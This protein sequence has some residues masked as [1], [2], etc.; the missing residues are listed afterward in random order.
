MNNAVFNLILL[1]TGLFLLHITGC[2]KDDVPFDNTALYAACGTGQ[3]YARYYPDGPCTR[4][5][6]EAGMVVSGREGQFCGDPNRESDIVRLMVQFDS[7]TS[8]LHP[9]DTLYM[10]YKSFAP[11]VGGFR[12]IGFAVTVNNEQVAWRPSGCFEE[13]SNTYREKAF[14]SSRQG[15]SFDSFRTSN[16]DQTLENGERFTMFL[17]NADVNEDCYFDLSYAEG[18]VRNDTAFLTA[19]WIPE[20]DPPELRGDTLLI[21][22]AIITKIPD[23]H[24][25]LDPS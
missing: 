15:L 22:T 1:I 13:K 10:E 17:Y 19:A 18:F 2:K 9:S 16:G 11:T 5:R 14:L 8:A 6:T 25:F 20:V 7:V 24:P 3:V 4:C 12:T 23:D 21:S